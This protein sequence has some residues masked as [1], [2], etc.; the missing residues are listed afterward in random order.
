MDPGMTL[1]S[2]STCSRTSISTKSSKSRSPIGKP[3][4]QLLD[5]NGVTCDGLGRLIGDCTTKLVIVDQLGNGRVLSTDGALGILT[6]P[7]LSPAHLQRVIDL[8]PANQRFADP[9]E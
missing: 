6:D 2:R 3:L 8:Q 1:I 7:Q 9:C 4:R 5:V